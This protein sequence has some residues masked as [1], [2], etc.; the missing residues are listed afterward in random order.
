MSGNRM[1]QATVLGRAFARDP[2]M[3]FVLPETGVRH[4]KLT[5]LFRPILRTS[6]K[7]GGIASDKQRRAV[8][9]WVSIQNFPI[10]PL[11]MI[12]N[13]LFQTL[14]AIGWRPILRLAEHEH[15][16]DKAIRRIAPPRT[17]YLRAVGVLPEHCGQGHG[18]RI[19]RH[20]LETMSDEGHKACLLKTENVENVPIYEALGF[21]TVDKIIVPSSGL[22]VWVMG[23]QI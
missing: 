13:G 2:L 23:R 7:F 11:D 15:V 21:Q 8:A 10:S 14:Q 6:A 12:K 9:A 18:G 20:V 17:G 4:R 1:D 3:A 16:V 5:P 19:V 22:P